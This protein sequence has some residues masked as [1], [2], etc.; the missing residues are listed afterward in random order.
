MAD[1]TEMSDLEVLESEE[2]NAEEEA[3]GTSDTDSSG[4]I[5]TEG[6][7]TTDEIEQGEDEQEEAG[8][9][10]DESAEGVDVGISVKALE[11]NF[12]QIFKKFPTLKSALWR[13]QKFTE[14]FPTLE[15][16]RDAHRNA[17]AFTNFESEIMSGQSQNLLQNVKNVDDRAFKKFSSNFLNSLQKVDAEAFNTAVGPVVLR[18]IQNIYATG[19]QHNN[20]DLALS[21]QHISR[22]LFG[23]PNV[24]QVRPPETPQDGP[25]EEERRIR[26]EREKFFSERKNIVLTE[27]IE[28]TDSILQREIEK[29]LGEMNEFTRSA[30]SD[31]ILRKVN[32]VLASDERHMNAMRSMWQKAEQA[33]FSA[34]WRNRIRN[35]Y[36]IRARAVLPT[37]RARAKS[38]ASKKPAPVTASKNMIPTGR[39]TSGNSGGKMP[40]SSKQ[41]DYSKTSDLDIL[42]GRITRKKT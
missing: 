4:E 14:F 22:Y 10:E 20:E 5:D 33:G 21:A 38:E 40:I 1:E 25:S 16:A 7:E 9:K 26:Q 12:P 31:K 39:V 3:T 36:L 41:I 8:A 34:E 42:E 11:K 30:L 27:V 15:Q 23:N 37:I 13:E 28:Q 2:P 32:D 18:V 29:G 24:E 35:Y 19:L 17:A 6:A